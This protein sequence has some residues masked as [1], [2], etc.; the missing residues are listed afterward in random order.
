MSKKLAWALCLLGAVGG[1]N[2]GKEKTDPPVAPDAPTTQKAAAAA[3]SREN[4][5]TR[6]IGEF[7][8][9]VSRV[10]YGRDEIV[11]VLNNE[12]VVICKRVPSPALTVRAYVKAGSVYEARWMGGGLSHLLE[13]LVAG[14]TNDRRTEAQNRDL[15]QDLGNNSNA[16]TTATHTSYFVNTTPKQLEPAVDLIAGWVFGAHITPAEYAREYQ[17]VQR[18]LEMGL[19]EP[20]SVFY[21][22]ALRNRYQVSPA[23][24]PVIGYQDVIRGLSR[25][26]VYA[27]YKLAYVPNNMVFVVAGDVDPEQML[28]AV[29][30][31]ANIPPGR[32]FSHDIAQEPPVTTPRTLVSTFPKLG[33]AKVQ[34]GFPSIML[35]HEDLYAL[36]LLATVLGSGESSI[37]VEEVRD[38]GLVSGVMAYSHTPHHV[39]GTFGIQ[40]EAEHDKVAAASKAILE[41]VAKVKKDGVPADRIARAKTQMKTQRAFGLLTTEQIGESLAT[42]Y[43]SSGDPH[44]MDNYVERVQAVTAEQ[45]KAVANR[46]L[47]AGRLLTT[48]M[49]PQE[50]VA[51]KG[52][53]AAAEKLLRP[54]VPDTVEQTADASAVTRLELKDGTIVLLKR[55][56]T[57][58]VVSIKMYSLGGLTAEDAST[59]GI[60]SLTMQAISRGTATRSAQQIA[61][62]WDSIGGVM[63]GTMTNNHWSWDAT[64][65]KEDFGKAFEVFADVVKNPSFPKDEVDQVRK[66][67]LAQIEAQDADWNQ[68]SVRFARAKYF[69]PR[70]SPYQFMPVGTK[71]NV[72]KLTV[73]QMRTWYKDKVLAPGGRKVLAIYGDIDVAKT[74]AQVEK[75][76]GAGKDAPAAAKQVGHELLQA[77]DTSA[78]VEVKRVEVNPTQNPQAGVVVYFDSDSVYGSPEMAPI[79]MADT[80]SSGYGYPTGYLFETLRGQGL[81]YYVHA[82]ILQGKDARTPGA[83][84]VIAGCDPKDADKVVDG[85]LLNIARL[86]GKPQDLVPDWYERSKRLVAITDALNR[87]TPSDQAEKAAVDELFSLGHG[88]HA[89]FADRINNVRLSDVQNIARARLRN[90]TVTVTTNAPDAVK[91]KPGR[92]SFEAFPPVD[93]TPKGVTHD[94]K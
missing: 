10:V 65:L 16:Y 51:D 66:R 67:Q 44:F 62:F 84:M 86:Q 29:Q 92:R 90:C 39:D 73:E 94:A 74:R 41:Q 50:Y 5:R 48:A 54:I 31:N 27:Y 71:Q 7:A 38:K 1:C 18:E 33:E 37:L 47:D 46:Y 63:A 55:I 3:A 61:G 21:D 34:L 75:E 32:G 59:N 25:D 70:N 79:I 85:I 58:P 91:T 68:Q 36:D 78:A 19:G 52:G 89:G 49:V 9:E 15:L 88:F 64:C 80:M 23:K 8:K 26:D 81:V 72:E 77:S 12:M 53:L 83:F 43:L 93:L 28:Q 40:F 60:G 69:G 82:T 17:V 45:L 42:D 6:D 13:H 22:Q 24:V 30:R 57:S 76:F 11:S 20:D 14:G 56:T 4:G 35:L 2:N 87:E